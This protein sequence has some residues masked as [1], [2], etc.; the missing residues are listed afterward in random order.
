MI[1]LKEDIST[2]GEPSDA[3]ERKELKQDIVR[4][5][6]GNQD[7][8][9]DNQSDE[10]LDDLM[11]KTLKKEDG[12][13][14]VL[15]NIYEALECVDGSEEDYIEAIRVHMN[16]KLDEAKEIYGDI[17]REKEDAKHNK[18]EESLLLLDLLNA[19]KDN[20]KPIEKG[21]YKASSYKGILY[22]L[23]KM[24]Y[25]FDE[26]YYKEPHQ[27]ITAKKGGKCFEMEL[28][29]YSDG[30]YE[31]MFDNVHEV[32]CDLEESMVPPV[33]NTVDET[34]NAEGYQPEDMNV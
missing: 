28:N 23:D 33:E 1:N 10:Q 14:N 4:A 30:S 3:E 2:I 7:L 15:D 22:F 24:G 8:E 25:D 34:I 9:L 11:Y 31:L 27:F 29:R 19:N 18:L 26:S 17:L 21:S 6:L 12:M 16:V 5:A 13:D 32:P 20:G